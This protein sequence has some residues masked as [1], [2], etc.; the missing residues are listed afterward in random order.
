MNLV[1][2]LRGVMYA[3]KGEKDKGK[4]QGP[5]LD[6][7]V[8]DGVVLDAAA[9]HELIEA[10][11]DAV[12]AIQQWVEDSDLDDGES[13]ADRLLALMVGVA[14]SNKDGELTDDEQDVVQAV[15]EAAWDYLS[16]F[17]AAEDDISALLNDWD[18]DAAERLRDLVAAGLPEGEDEADAA[19]DSFAFGEADQEAALDNAVLDA[20]YRKRMVIRNGKKM[21]VNKRVSGTVRLSGKQKLAIRKASLKSRSAGAKARRMK[22]MKL[23]RK[24]GL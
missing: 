6:S 7:A 2:S 13:S 14:D 5:A 22:S 1:D 9:E 15:L 11:K 16:S 23:R 21:R 24:M 10:R 3:P 17:G 8:L 18:G 4:R 19:I 20:T 12:A